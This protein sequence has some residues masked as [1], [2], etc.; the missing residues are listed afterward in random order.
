M[1]R[2]RKPK[3]NLTIEQQIDLVD[4]QI[5]DYKKELSALKAK[6]KELVAA[7]DKEEL[8]ALFAAL[9]DQGMSAAEAIAKLTQ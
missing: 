6:R 7:K 5:K 9:K 2:G 8:E 4:A 1:A 3:I